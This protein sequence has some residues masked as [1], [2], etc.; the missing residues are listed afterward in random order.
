MISNTKKFDIFTRVRITLNYSGRNS[1]VDFPLV[2][3]ALGSGAFSACPY[4][5]ATA[6]PDSTD[7]NPGATLFFVAPVFVL[8]AQ[9]DYKKETAP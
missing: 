6:P 7:T 5:V 4:N 8:V 3:E 1:S 9:F 2:E